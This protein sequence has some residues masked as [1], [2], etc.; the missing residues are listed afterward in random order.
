MTPRIRKILLATGFSLLIWAWAYQASDKSIEKPATL[1]V[2]RAINPAL[3]VTFGQTQKVDFRI[4]ITG[5]ALQVSELEKSLAKG[6]EQLEF[7]FNAEE[8]KMVSP[9]THSLNLL[10]FL[11]SSNKM[12]ALGLTVESCSPEKIQVIVE[13]LKE[14]VLPVHCYN[15]NGLLIE[16]EK[17][18]PPA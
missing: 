3:F 6:E 2:S 11:K 9:G 14:Q 10:Q 7:V 15:E 12:T 4:T 13:N 17:I 5:P 16:H 8:Q 18:T 1:T